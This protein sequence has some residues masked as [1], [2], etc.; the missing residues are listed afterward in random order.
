MQTELPF[1]AI[2]FSQKIILIFFLLIDFFLPSKI[3][4]VEDSIIVFAARKFSPNCFP[5]FSF[6]YNK[7]NM[8]LFITAHPPWPPNLCQCQCFP[9]HSIVMYTLHF[10]PRHLI[11]YLAVDPQFVWM[12]AGYQAIPTLH[13]FIPIS[14][15][16]VEVF[17]RFLS[18]SKCVV[19]LVSRLVSPQNSLHRKTLRLSS[20]GGVFTFVIR[21]PI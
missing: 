12:H 16:G 21:F 1:S 15:A 6:F 5:I 4:A 9:A 13:T 17:M 10:V 18:F 14:T 2:C 19:L 7:D 11:L 3:F 8:S 20:Q